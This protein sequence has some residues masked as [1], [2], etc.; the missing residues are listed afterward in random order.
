MISLKKSTKVILSVQISHR[1]GGELH[2]GSIEMTRPTSW[3]WLAALA[4]ILAIGT[5]PAIAGNQAVWDQD[6]G[7]YGLVTGNA[8]ADVALNID[9]AD[10]W[11]EQ[12]FGKANA[13]TLEEAI[14]TT[15]KKPGA[16]VL[17]S[18]FDVIAATLN[19]AKLVELSTLATL[20]GDKMDRPV[21]AGPSSEVAMRKSP[22]PSELANTP[23]D[24]DK[25]KQP[26]APTV[27]AYFSHCGPATGT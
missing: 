15:T 4:V 24:V 19:T 3:A 25:M 13:A 8:G 10:T 1:V 21:R 14:A 16:A 9:S 12:A 27:T 20:S 26:T 22:K 7:S 2:N 17:Q 11:M 23:T 6:I 18:D 5:T